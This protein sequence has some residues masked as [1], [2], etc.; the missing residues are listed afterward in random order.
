MF[1]IPFLMTAQQKRDFTLAVSPTAASK[2]FYIEN[3]EDLRAN[4]AIGQLSDSTLVM[5]GGLIKNL[6]KHWNKL[7]AVDTTKFPVVLQIEDFQIVEKKAENKHVTG[8][9]V[10]S[11]NVVWHNNIKPTQLYKYQTSYFLKRPNNKHPDYENFMT[12]VLEKALKNINT[13]FEKNI[14]YNPLLAHKVVVN[15]LPDYKPITPEKDTL[16]YS[17]RKL[18][19]ADF[20]GVVNSRS[21]YGGIIESSWAYVLKAQMIN[22]EIHVDVTMKAYAIKNQSWVRENSKSPY[23]LLH[24]QGHFDIT[25]IIVERFKAKIA[26]ETFLPEDYDSRFNYLFIETYREMNE[27]QK[28]YDYETQHSVDVAKQ[29]E[30]NNKIKK[31]LQID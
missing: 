12:N 22:R 15:I 29:S 1:K 27:L 10:C 16:F 31:E 8:S 23:T 7:R 5:K 9:F 17:E 28:Q 26:K 21:Q 18:E 30:W 13:W 6:E 19:W 3:I 25:Q 20:K 24:E 2:Y 14:D 11:I 4:K